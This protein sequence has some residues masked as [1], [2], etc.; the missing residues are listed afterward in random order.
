MMP[1]SQGLVGSRVESCIYFAHSFCILLTRWYCLPGQRSVLRIVLQTFGSD[2]WLVRL[3]IC[4]TMGRGKRREVSWTFIE[5][6]DSDRI[7]CES[8]KYQP[9]GLQS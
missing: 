6:S 9:P 7:L 4:I 1:A 3:V 5:G 8:I 2:S